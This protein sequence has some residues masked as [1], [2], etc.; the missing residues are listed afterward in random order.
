MK[1]SHKSILSRL[2]DSVRWTG[3]PAR[4]A[5]DMSDEPSVD[6]NHRPLRWSPLLLI[7]FSCVLLILCLILLSNVSPAAVVGIMTAMALS[8]MTG[9]VLVYSSGPLGKPSREDDEREAALR[10]DSFLFCLGLLAGLNCL[11]QPILLVL[12]HWQNWQAGQSVIVAFCAL[13]LNATLLATLPTLYAS[14]NSR[15]LPRE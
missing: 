7:A 14:W 1:R 8:I 6:R 2:D 15:R 5:D 12:S 13:I 11:G 9:G 10:K 3:I 4:V